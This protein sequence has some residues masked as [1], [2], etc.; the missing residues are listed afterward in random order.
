MSSKNLFKILFIINLFVKIKMKA[1]F[2]RLKIFRLLKI[3]KTAHF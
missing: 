3:N 2:F 1:T